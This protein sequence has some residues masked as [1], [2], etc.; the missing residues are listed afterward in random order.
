[1]KNDFNDYGQNFRSMN[2]LNNIEDS[3]FLSQKS[4]DQ[5]LVSNIN[6]N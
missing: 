3:L 2:D 4:T 6:S 1:M 5:N